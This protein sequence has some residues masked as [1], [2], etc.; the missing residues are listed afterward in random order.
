[1]LLKLDVNQLHYT[2]ASCLRLKTDPAW[3]EDRR[4]C[5]RNSWPTAA[6]RA[7][8]KT[9]VLL[10]AAAIQAYSCCD[11]CATF[12]FTLR[13]TAV[14]L[15]LQMAP[16]KK[17]RAEQQADTAQYTPIVLQRCSA[18]PWR[19]LPIAAV[20]PCPDG[21]VLAVAR[22]DGR[23]EFWDTSAW[24]CITVR[25]EH[26]VSQGMHGSECASGC[27]IGRHL[28]PC[29]QR[30]WQS[31][32]AWHLTQWQLPGFADVPRQRRGIHFEP[33]VGLR[34]G[35]KSM[36][37]LLSWSGWPPGGMESA[38]RSATVHHPLHWW[39]SMGVGG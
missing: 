31:L 22:D 16:N 25:T 29:V 8:K 19:P 3:R 28:Q 24:V 37:P 9:N 17:R 7:S 33:G 27:S 10:Q 23:I 14:A 30:K 4:P 20:Q 26:A 2:S 18:V 5:G 35:G 32:H 13:L 6:A 38:P 36:A 11:V 39:C 1:M 21:S 15:R 34:C 12:G